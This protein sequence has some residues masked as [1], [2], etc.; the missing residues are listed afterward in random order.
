MNLIFCFL[1]QKQY[2]AKFLCGNIGTFNKI[3]LTVLLTR[4]FSQ[5]LGSNTYYSSQV[6]VSSIQKWKALLIASIGISKDLL[7]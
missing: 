6:I 4:F 3:F 2:T 1:F 7:L 5:N